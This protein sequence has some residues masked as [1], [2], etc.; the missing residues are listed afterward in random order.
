MDSRL[1]PPHLFHA[2]FPPRRHLLQRYL[3]EW[4]TE[5]GPELAGDPE[6]IQGLLFLVEEAA[7][8][9][10]VDNHYEIKWFPSGFHI[11]EQDE[12]AGALFLLLSGHADVVREDARGRHLTTRLQPGQFFGEQGIASGLPYAHRNVHVIAADSVCCVVLTA[13]QLAPFQGRGE[14]ARMA[15]HETGAHSIVTQRGPEVAFGVEDFLQTKLAA[16]AAHRTRFSFRPELLPE[17]MLLDLF[18][19][20]YFVRVPVASEAGARAEIQPSSDRGPRRPSLPAQG[21]G[22]LGHWLRTALHCAPCPDEPLWPRLQDYPY[23][24]R[25]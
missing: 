17:S 18:G 12:P 10:C 21:L 2:Q 4:L 16:L 6:F 5:V 14:G 15:P 19:L 13:R 25:P 24:R 7:T 1:A 8:L 20:E 22:M 23:G 3:V 9:R 11:I